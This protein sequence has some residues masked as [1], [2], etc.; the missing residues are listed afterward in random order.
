MRTSLPGAGTTAAGH[1]AVFAGSR[2]PGGQGL[3]LVAARTGLRDAQAVEGGHRPL[4]VGS[5][6]D[7]HKA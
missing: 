5:R 6:A 2:H 4:T 1:P 3:R 7:D